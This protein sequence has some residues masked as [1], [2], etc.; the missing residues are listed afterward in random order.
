MEALHE[1]YPL[2]GFNKHNGY[3]TAEHKRALSEFGPCPI[4]RRCYRP[5]KEAEKQKEKK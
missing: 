4:H 1:Q 5:V 3:P 2:Y